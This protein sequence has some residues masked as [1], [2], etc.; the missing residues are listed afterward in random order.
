MNQ[1]KYKIRNEIKLTKSRIKE[2]SNDIKTIKNNI[3]EVNTII[4]KQTKQVKKIIDGLNILGD[5]DVSISQKDYFNLKNNQELLDNRMKIKNI[6]LQLNE[7]LENELK[8]QNDHLEHILYIKELIELEEEE[9]KDKKE[10]KKSETKLNK[11]ISIRNEEY[12]NIKNE[13]ESLRDI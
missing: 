11:L 10:L 13:L 9:E 4:D 2:L 6:Y 5:T 12:K 3:N 8:K 1:D 7:T